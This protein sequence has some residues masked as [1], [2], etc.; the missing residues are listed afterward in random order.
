MNKHFPVRLTNNSI[1]FHDIKYINI[2]IN[3]GT[4]NLELVLCLTNQNKSINQS[5]YEIDAMKIWINL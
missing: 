1:I 4:F 3:V 5:S 2:F